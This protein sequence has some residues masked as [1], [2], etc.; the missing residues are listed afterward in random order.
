MWDDPKNSPLMLAVM[1]PPKECVITGPVVE[2]GDSLGSSLPYNKAVVQLVH[3]NGFALVHASPAHKA[4]MYK[5]LDDPGMLQVSACDPSACK[6]VTA[7]FHLVTKSAKFRDADQFRDTLAAAVDK[8]ADDSDHFVVKA[9]K[10]FEAIDDQV[11]RS[12]TALIVATGDFVASHS[13]LFLLLVL[14]CVQ[15]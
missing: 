8:Q 11:E 15:R 3:K 1:S 2:R 13:H 5:R 10:F 7:G 14:C 12:V 6:Y 4:R 9:I